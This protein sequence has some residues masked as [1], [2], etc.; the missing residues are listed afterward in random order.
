MSRSRK[1]PFTLSTRE[2]LGAVAVL[3][4]SETDEITLTIADAPA[5]VTVSTVLTLEQIV[6]LQDAL[7]S[8]YERLIG[9]LS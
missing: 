6:E 9:E 5:H 1:I 8:A 4:H 7:E 3:V 2:G